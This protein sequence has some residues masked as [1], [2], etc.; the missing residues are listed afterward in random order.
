MESMVK[1]AVIT[2][3][4]DRPIFLAR[5]LKSVARQTYG[6][7]IHVIVNDGGNKDD[8]E[9]CIKSQAPSVQEK[10]QL[11]HREEPSG[12][13]DSIFSESIDRVDSEYVAL[14]DDDDTWHP[15]FLKVTVG[16]LE[17]GAQGVVVRTDN[18]YEKLEG[19]RI[20]KK[21]ESRY[22]PDLRAVS[23]YAQCLDNQ[24]T[25]VAFVYRRKAYE[26]VGKYDA[27]LPVV[28]D[29]EFGIRFLMR[30]DVEYIDPGFAL[31]YY[32]RR[33]VGDNSFAKHSHH[34]YITKVLNQYLR[35]DI[36]Q[37]K[38]GVGYIMNKL[39]AERDKNHRIRRTVKRALPT[40]VV[41]TLGKYRP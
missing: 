34:K 10:I 38:F 20:I 32:H 27:T 40:K 1:V 31:A 28:G 12:A 9:S 5:A 18:I 29:W 22:L 3:T 39:W 4:K 19:S 36:Q 6:D 13:P 17:A 30:Y 35:E 24:L 26:E 11:F 21:K 23:L 7:Y 41:R 15:D 2:R 37:G 33:V 14:H 16:A 8:V 25:A